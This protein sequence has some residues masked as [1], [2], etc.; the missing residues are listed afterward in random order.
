[1][2][3][4]S[5]LGDRK[6]ENKGRMN[7]SYLFKAVLHFDALT[8]K[9]VPRWLVRDHENVRDEQH[10]HF[11][12]PLSLLLSL[13][14]FNKSP[15]PSFK[16]PGCKKHCCSPRAEL[17]VVSALQK[18]L[19][20]L[21]LGHFFRACFVP[22]TGRLTGHTVGSGWPPP[23]R[24]QAFMA[25]WRNSHKWECAAQKVCGVKRKYK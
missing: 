19:R 1:M 12:H 16:T 2:H 15:L 9:I 22:R 8:S 4:L 25:T 20:C 5:F 17:G 14:L 18:N 21:C 10:L 7:L 13:F 24:T 23:P 6:Y 11:L 3:P